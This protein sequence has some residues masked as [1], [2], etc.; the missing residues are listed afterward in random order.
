MQTDVGKRP[1]TR[2]EFYQMLERGEFDGK[3]VE[4]IDGVVVEMAP[5][6]NF[7]A[8]GVTLTG[9]ALRQ[10]FGHGY[11]VREQSTLD[12][13]PKFVPD[14]GVAVVVGS[15]KNPSANNPTSALLVVEVSETSLHDDRTDKASLYVTAGIT[16]YWIVNLIDRQVEVHRSPQPDPSQ[17]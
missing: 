7:H 1:V 15:P 16:D 10:V 8:A 2:D 4:L 14:P 11:W 6:K 5:Q 12:L 3:R 9:I 17:M 13:S